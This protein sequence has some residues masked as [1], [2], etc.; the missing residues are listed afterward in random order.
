MPPLHPGVYHGQYVAQKGQKICVT[1]LEAG[2]AASPPSHTGCSVAP[3][4]V[5][6]EVG[7]LLNHFLLPVFTAPR[8]LPIQPNPLPVPPIGSHERGRPHS[9]IM[10]FSPQALPPAPYGDYGASGPGSLLMPRPPPRGGCNFRAKSSPLAYGSR[11]LLKLLNHEGQDSVWLFAGPRRWEGCYAQR[12]GWEHSR[13]Q[14]GLQE[15]A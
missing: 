8:P 11:F 14:H 13:S 15:L 9:L 6:A 5:R 7:L 4:S 3:K 2:I 1:H 10:L 12:A